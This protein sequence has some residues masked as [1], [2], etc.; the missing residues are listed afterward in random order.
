[1]ATFF[2][3]LT[4]WFTGVKSPCQQS[5]FVT[6]MDW[7]INLSFAASIARISD[8]WVR[9]QHQSKKVTVLRYRYILAQLQKMNAL[10]IIEVGPGPA[11]IIALANVLLKRHMLYYAAEENPLFAVQLNNYCTDLRL[12]S[13][14]KNEP[15]TCNSNGADFDC[16]V[17]EHSLEDLY[18]RECN[19]Q[20][21]NDVEHSGI[22]YHQE[23]LTSEFSKFLES[24]ISVL[25]VS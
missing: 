23:D 5:Q 6:H 16:L 3:Q 18:L 2:L 13:E 24:T 19:I 10:K 14:I 11:S 15:F 25:S 9:E 22:C 12:N 7:L 4:H 8:Y 17:F 21:R 20:N 1:M